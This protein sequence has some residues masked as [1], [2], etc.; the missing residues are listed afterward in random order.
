MGLDQQILRIKNTDLEKFHALK[1]DAVIAPHNPKLDYDT[2]QK[3]AKE[4]RELEELY[5]QAVTN[6]DPDAEIYRVRIEDLVAPYEE[7]SIWY[8][9]K[10][11]HIH[12]WVRSAAGLDDTNLDYVL[13]DP[14]ALLDD[15]KAVLD[16][17]D[18]APEA[19]PTTVGFFFGGTEYDDYYIGSVR[20]LY[21]TLVLEKNQGFFDTCSY[22][23]WSWW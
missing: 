23:Y 18:K 17:P 4:C 9:R 1:G 19:L 7:P 22:F 12:E 15:L 6:E 14:N 3:T 16:D 21:N 13:I 8:G 5:T 10:E 2:I 11:N 20:H